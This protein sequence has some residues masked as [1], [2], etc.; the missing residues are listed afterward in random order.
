[1]TIHTNELEGGKDGDSRE[2]K[3]LP[4]LQKKSRP[5]RSFRHIPEGFHFLLDGNPHP[6][7][8]PCV[9]QI[10]EMPIKI[11]HQHKISKRH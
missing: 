11:K 4:S 7:L 6:L 3:M 1:M 10:F 2:I 5:R 8:I 9:S